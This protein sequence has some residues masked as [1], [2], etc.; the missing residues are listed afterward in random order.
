MNANL[1]LKD[2]WYWGANFALLLSAFVSMYMSNGIP[3]LLVGAPLVLLDRAYLVPM[4]LFLACIEGSFKVE[5]VSSSTE[6][7]AIMLAA[8]FLVFD[9]FQKNGEKVPLK[10]TLLY[11]GWLLFVGIGFYTYSSHPYIRQFLVPTLGKTAVQSP[12]PKMFKNLIKIAFFFIYLKVLI[13]KDK[14]FFRRALMLIKDM[15]P[16]LFVLILLNMLVSGREAEKYDTLHFGEAKHGDFSANCNALGAFLYIS[17]FEIKSNWYKRG[18][19]LLAL[20][21]LCYVV[22]NL[23]SRNGL[24]QF[25]ILG[26]LAGSLVL[27][28]RNWGFKFVSAAAA[29]GALMAMFV[30]FQD[31]PTLARLEVK[32]AGGDRLDYWTAGLQGVAEE[33]FFGLGG[34]DSVS[35]YAVGKY[36][37]GIDDHVMHNTFIEFMVQFGVIGFLFYV[38]LVF[39]IL[40][41]AYK[42]YM[43]GIK[44]NEL[45]LC[46][47]SIS[48]VIS[49]FAG[50]FISR[51]WETTLWYHMTF[52]FVIYI[53]YRMPVEDALKKRKG[54]IIRGLPDPLNSPVFLRTY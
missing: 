34:D 5:G 27:W 1:K 25:M 46:V 22:L 20:G 47:P 26:L 4:L 35:F 31:S 16:Y 21:C 48:Y 17:I 30:I 41:H 9:F 6:S 44:T 50:F 29:V 8:P 51:I 10:F 38:T 15:A 24:L 40:Y 12:Y 28:N 39:T 18:I 32:E 2:M 36:A 23:G 7:E 52:V 14:D 37:P 53:T 42:N 43:F 19:A 54:F 45:L 49:I 11:L 3:I 33:P 13:N